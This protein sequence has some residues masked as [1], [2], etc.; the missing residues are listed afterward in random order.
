MNFFPPRVSVSVSPLLML[1]KVLGK[2]A[3]IS[4]VL[5]WVVN[6]KVYW[7]LLLLLVRFCVDTCEQTATER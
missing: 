6:K 7:F 5:D 4:T 1:P 2:E 3:G